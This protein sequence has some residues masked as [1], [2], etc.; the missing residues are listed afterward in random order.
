MV[1]VFCGLLC[2]RVHNSLSTAVTVIVMGKLDTSC[3][4]VVSNISSDTIFLF[5]SV[6]VVRITMIGFF[7]VHCAH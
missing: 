7:L 5:F 1:N 4:F 6:I 2:I 3:R